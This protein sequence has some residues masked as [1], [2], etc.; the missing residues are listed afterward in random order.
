M[1]CAVNVCFSQRCLM[2]MPN[3]SPP[4]TESSTPSAGEYATHLRRLGR[5]VK[6]SAQFLSFWLAIGLPFVYLPLL[7]NGLG[8]PTVA[9]T[10]VTLL[11]V[12]VL[13]LYAG[14]GYN[15]T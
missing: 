9:L 13:A 11:F 1:L 6:P 7:A 14:H 5:T 10:F 8:D 2:T 3:P 12:N 15:R 4:T